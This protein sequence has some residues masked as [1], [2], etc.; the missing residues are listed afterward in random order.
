MFGTKSL[1]SHFCPLTRQ[2]STQF[3]KV[4][5]C[6]AQ[7]R[8]PNWLEPASVAASRCPDCH[9]PSACYEV[10]L[11]THQVWV[12][13]FQW[14]ISDFTFH[15]SIYTDIGWLTPELKFGIVTFKKI[16]KLAFLGL[17][18]KKKK[19]LFSQGMKKSL[20]IYLNAGRRVEMWTYLLQTDHWGL[21][22]S[23]LTPSNKTSNEER[24]CVPRVMEREHKQ[25]RQ[26]LS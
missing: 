23:G 15:S 4:L 3:H 26:W 19:N 6:I 10:S 13:W 1:G 24:K 8:P 11:K 25:T 14:V 16:S 17:N 5:H 2:I 9:F 22:C 12:F 7:W 20:S 21:G 18:L